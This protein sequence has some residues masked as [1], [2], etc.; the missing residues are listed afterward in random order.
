MT[1]AERHNAATFIQHTTV[2][3]FIFMGS[4]FKCFF[5]LQY[6]SEIPTL[7]EHTSAHTTENEAS[8]LKKYLPK[9]K[10]TLQADI[11][12]LKCRMCNGK[13]SNLDTIKEHLQLHHGTHFF[14][15]SNGMTEYNIPLVC[16]MLVC[17]LCNRTF[18][19]FSLLNSHMNCHVGKVIC[20][21]CG[22]RFLTQ[23]LL[24]KHKELH[25]H[26]R[27]S[28]KSCD[29]DFKKKSQLKYHTQI[30][31]KGIERLKLNKCPECFKT[32]KE[33]YS[34]ILHLKQAHGITKSF[35]CYI[36]KVTFCMRRS[37]TEHTTKYHT[38]KY[39]CKVCSKCYA[40][41]FRLKQHMRGHTG[42]KNFICPICN[43]AYMHKITLR[44]HMRSHDTLT[45]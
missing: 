21:K 11:S 28:C 10:R 3:P 15:V 29:K 20:E 25:I 36:C 45:H 42:E 8:I 13:F 18:H 39:K 34:K 37:L 35:E 26:K 38:E 16:N 31:H 22:V 5:C 6:Y 33:H 1:K 19:N 44:K 17:H 2:R 43:N 12:D 27:F 32:F 4:S 9:G 40:T 23:H 7:L 14:A 41:E 30:I 24:M